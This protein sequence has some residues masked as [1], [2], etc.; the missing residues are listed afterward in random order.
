MTMRCALAPLL[1]AN[2]LSAAVITPLA[3]MPNEIKSTSNAVIPHVVDGGFWKTSFKFVNLDVHTVTFYV[4]FMHDD[5]SAMTL[6]IVGNDSLSSLTV[7]LTPAES[8]TL[9]TS[10][11]ASSLTSGWAL[12]QQQ[13][14]LDSLGTSAIFR[15]HVPG[16]Q[17]Q[18]ASVPIVTQGT[19]AFSV[20]F[21]N[22][23]YA[24]GIAL[25]NPNPTAIPVNAYIRDRQGTVIDHQTVLLPAMGHVAFSVSSRWPS[26]AGMEGAVEFVP[27]G[28]SVSALGLRFNGAAF[29]TFKVFQTVNWVPSQ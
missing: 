28:Y 13:N 14:P 27:A 15:Q 19:S 17:D 16:G 6:P 18:E 12:V 9:E 11:T 3:S 29:T 4:Y 22:T 20:L 10:G 8:L 24:T 23:A 2:V 25:A 26:T 7:A 5:G 21:D 1:F